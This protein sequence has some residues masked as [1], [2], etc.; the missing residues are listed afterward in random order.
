MN[1]NSK[2]KR[3]EERE[4]KREQSPKL[5]NGGGGNGAFARRQRASEYTFS[6][7]PIVCPTGF[8][9]GEALNDPA[10][11]GRYVGRFREGR[12]KG[13]KVFHSPPVLPTLPI[14]G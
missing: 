10:G 13:G 6:E 4:R 5:W 14:W 11:P 7:A 12:F 9:R 1:N 3:S 2:E 8:E